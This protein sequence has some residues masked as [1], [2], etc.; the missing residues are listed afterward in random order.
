MEK[1]VTRNL[2]VVKK[3]QITPN[4]LRITLGGDELKNFPEGEEGGYVKVLLKEGNLKRSY[5]IR[6]FRADILELDVD[7]FLHGGNGEAGPASAWA[8]NVSIGKEINITG[9]GSVKRIT[10]SEDWYFI[11]GDMTALPAISVNLETM[12]RNAKG[13]AVIEIIEETDKQEIDSPEGMTVIW[14]INPHP[15]Q[16]NTILPDAV[17]ALPWLEGKPNVWLAC[18]FGGMKLLRTYFKRE[19][20]VS[21]NELYISSYWKIG[22]TAEGHKKSKIKDNIVKM[23]NY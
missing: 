11:A 6:A 23:F 3:Q 21:K 5:T 15:N 4:M 18:E 10:T 22:V 20:S 13:Y 12:P 17:K 9:P 19:N 7:F 1:H 8:T 16:V 14:V 2:T